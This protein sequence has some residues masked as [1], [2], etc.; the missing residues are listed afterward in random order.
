MS[1][2]IRIIKVGDE[3]VNNFPLM[4][5]IPLRDQFLHGGSLLRRLGAID[6]KW[7]PDMVYAQISVKGFIGKYVD[8]SPL[9]LALDTFKSLLGLLIAQRGLRIIYSNSASTTDINAY[10]HCK[11][12]KWNI[13][14]STK[15]ANEFA[16][17]VNDLEFDDLNGTLDNDVKK[18][19]FISYTFTTLTK[20]LSKKESEKLRLAGRWLFDSYCGN[21]E[22]LSFIQ[23]TVS[24]E[25]LLGDK[26]KSDLMGLGELLRNRC[27]YLIGK[28]HTEREQVL[29]DF[30]KIYDI[31]SK[32]VHRG[33]SQLSRIDREL[34]YKLRW[35]ATRVIQ[36]EIELIGKNVQQIT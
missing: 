10:I 1:P 9:N 29:N 24:L 30:K 36:E 12:E 6:T 33:K 11:T 34:F 4:S 3:L 5:G 25:I 27:A 14:G 13:E 16:K 8:T 15:L 31:R 28:T 7:T 23:A 17:T 18:T 26:E 32:I 35:M 2:D 20:A 19:R 22:L 21:N